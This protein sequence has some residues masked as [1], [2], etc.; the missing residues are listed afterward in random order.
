MDAARRFAVTVDGIGDLGDDCQ[1][2]HNKRELEDTD[3]GLLIDVRSIV[4]TSRIEYLH[5]LEAIDL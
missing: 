3:V 5:K 4:Y 2:D 1:D